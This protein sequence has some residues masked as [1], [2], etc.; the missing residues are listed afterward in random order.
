M[1]ICNECGTLVEDLP[2]YKEYHP[3]GD[4]YAVE[5]LSDDRCI[6]GGEFEEAE[7]CEDCQEYFVSDSLT[8]G[9]C[10][11]CYREED[12]DDETGA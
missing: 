10:A 1:Y 3:Y 6:C 11:D 12:D 5:I 2:T 8:D 9:L 4:S 7:R